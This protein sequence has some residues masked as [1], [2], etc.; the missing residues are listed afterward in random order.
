MPDSASKGNTVDD[1]EIEVTPTKALFVDMLTRDIG[2]NRAV[3][4]LIDNSVDGARRMRPDANPDYSGLEIIVDL[5]GTRFSIKDNCGG[6]GV[7]LARQYAFRIGRPKDMPPTPN[8]VGQFGVGMKR[9]LFKFGRTFTVR[10]ITTKDRF[11]LTVD[12][13]E[14]EKDESNWKFKFDEVET[15]ISIPK[16]QTGTEI[17][18]TRLRESVAEAFKL[19][20]FRN[21]LSREIQAAQ[22]EYIDRKL[23]IVFDGRTLIATPWQ[24]LGGQGIEPA[25]SED[26]YSDLGSEPVYLRIFAGIS[27]SK[28]R[29]A[30]WYV[31]CNGRMVLEADQSAITG[32][33]ALAESEGIAVPKY[34]NQF[35]RFRGYVFFD[36][37]DASLLP[38]N[39]TKTGVDE[40][41]P[42]FRAALL[43]MIE[44][45]RPIIN[46][47]NQLDSEKDNLSEERPLTTAVARAI[48]LSLRSITRLGPFVQ[49]TRAAS[50]GPSMVTIS[51]KRP[52]DQAEELQEALGARSAKDVGEKTFDLAYR[53]Y[54]EEN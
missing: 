37:K 29:E 38:W 24:L 11:E 15:G 45:M 36:C 40:D 12:V 6:I 5:D 20:N 43:K 1:N 3:I 39:T 28:P 51:Y 18:V 31:F 8:S 44:A 34:H 53:K 32:W 25:K 4:D 52:V 10:S 17:V 26:V 47:L 33:A 21:S 27:S 48:P 13:E 22:Q 50:R 46:F 7:D 16:E 54:V 19:A 30:G 23:R 49:P 9:A 42:L 14:W 2:L 35:A 41:A